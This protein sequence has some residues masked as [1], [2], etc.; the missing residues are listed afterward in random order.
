MLGADGRLEQSTRRVLYHVPSSVASGGE[1]IVAD[2]DCAWKS[3][4]ELPRDRVRLWGCLDAA[5]EKVADR[6]A[7]HVEGP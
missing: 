5:I 4:D 3:F 2:G 1:A 7:T 6:I